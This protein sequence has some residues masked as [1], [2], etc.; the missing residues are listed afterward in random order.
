MEWVVLTTSGKIDSQ[1][2]KEELVRCTG[3]AER[4]RKDLLVKKA[5]WR[6]NL[7]EVTTIVMRNG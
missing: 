6:K 2:D 1:G 3:S 5:K 7:H 4:K